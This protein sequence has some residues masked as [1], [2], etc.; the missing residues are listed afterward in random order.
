MKTTSMKQK[1][2]HLSFEFANS[3]GEI[4]PFTFQDPNKVITAQSVEEV[5]PSLNLVQR[6]SG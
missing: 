2:P 3:S 6:G 1:Q 5:M 4:T